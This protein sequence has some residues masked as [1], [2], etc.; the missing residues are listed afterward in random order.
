MQIEM[1]KTRPALSGKN[2]I[3]QLKLWHDTAIS[4]N[5]LYKYKSNLLIY[6]FMDVLVFVRDVHTQEIWKFWNEVKNNL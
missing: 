4:W 3:T 2:K 5:G 1:Q 6:K